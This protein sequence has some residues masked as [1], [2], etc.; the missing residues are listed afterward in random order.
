MNH[1]AKIATCVGA[2]LVTSCVSNYYQGRDVG[3]RSFCLSGFSICSKREAV[4][5]NLGINN[6]QY[7]S[8]DEYLYRGKL[9]SFSPQSL[10]LCEKNN[11]IGIDYEIYSRDDYLYLSHSTNMNCEVR[12]DVAV[13]IISDINHERENK[14]ISRL[15]RIEDEKKYRESQQFSDDVFENIGVYR[16]FSQQ[17]LRYKLIKYNDFKSFNEDAI[18]YAKEITGERYSEDKMNRG[19]VDAN[20]RIGEGSIPFPYDYCKYIGSGGK[21]VRF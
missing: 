2:M 21:I 20:V 12:T 19:I 14:E 13:K 15:N 4:T 18:S 5:Y 6:F 16:A 1:F 17:C 10:I 9:S 11:S 7:I 3:V 8:S